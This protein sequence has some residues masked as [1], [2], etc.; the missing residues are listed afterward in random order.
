MLLTEN[1]AKAV[2]MIEKGDISQHQKQKIV[3]SLKFL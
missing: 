2:K 1:L 3:N